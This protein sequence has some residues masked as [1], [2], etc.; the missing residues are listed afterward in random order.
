MARMIPVT[1]KIQ[2]IS[3]PSGAEVRINS[4]LRGRTPITINDVD[5]SSAKRIELRL[6]DY[7]PFV[8]DLTWPSDGRI[9]IDAR[10]IR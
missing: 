3:T 10:L 1:G 6:K 4:E 8:Q 2:I 5:M 7:Q 9:Q